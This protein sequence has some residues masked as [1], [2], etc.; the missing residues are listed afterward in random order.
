MAHFVSG[1]G[2]EK[3]RVVRIFQEGS[4]K[5]RAVIYSSNTLLSGVKVS[6]LESF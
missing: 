4:L 3:R 6:R 1:L 2:L 5:E